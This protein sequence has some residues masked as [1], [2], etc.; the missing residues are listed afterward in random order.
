LADAVLE[1]RV[2]DVI[3][4]GVPLGDITVLKIE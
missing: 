1:A 4:A 3:E 2:G